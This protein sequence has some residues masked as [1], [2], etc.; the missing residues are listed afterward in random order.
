[1]SRYLINAAVNK[2][3]ILESICN[4]C[5]SPECTDVA[6]VCNSQNADI[7]L[8]STPTT[9]HIPDGQTL[10]PAEDINEKGNQ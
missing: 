6:Q 1:M 8:N 9:E 10:Q 4:I 3:H 2:F 5:N 7:H